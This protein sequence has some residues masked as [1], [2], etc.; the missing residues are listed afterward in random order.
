MFNKLK[1]VM[2]IIVLSIGIVS[3]NNFS[4][5]DSFPV[6]K[7][8]YLGQT[9]PGM[10][11][12][13]FA[14]GIISTQDSTEMDPAFTP[15]LKEFYYCFNGRY[16]YMQME[17]NI[18]SE[19]KLAS[20]SGQFPD[21]EA[22]ITL[23][24]KKLFFISR[25]PP[26]NWETW[27]VDK[28]SP[29]RWSSAKLIDSHLRGAFYPTVAK[30]GTLYFTGFW[31]SGKPANL[32]RSKYENGKFAAYEKLP[33]EVN[34]KPGTFEPYIAP[35]E[36][37]IIFGS[38][39]NADCFGGN[40]LYISFQVGEDSWTKAKNMG[41]GINTESHDSRPTMSPDGKYLFFSSN[42]KGTSDIFWV[43]AGIIEKLK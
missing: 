40:D 7:G 16:M 8:Q 32:Y 37:F 26:E 43:D 2:I 9:P 20:F 39:E 18:W 28:I 3:F 12:E 30:N 27:Y 35:D 21:L 1:L 14:S 29:G 4:Y 34:F 25:R 17:N 24:G 38:S 15:D 22:F 36:S 5:Q 6:L 41:E 31:D 19:P 33:E 10:I 42:R 13:I 11:P 23:D